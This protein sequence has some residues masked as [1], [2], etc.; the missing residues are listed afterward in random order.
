M[1]QDAPT[2]KNHPNYLS[3]AGKPGYNTGEQPAR[4]IGGAMVTFRG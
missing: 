2:G 3:P 4:A 1:I